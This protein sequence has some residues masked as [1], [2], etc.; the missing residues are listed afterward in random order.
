MAAIPW[1]LPLLFLTRRTSP[2]PGP[3]ENSSKQD[4]VYGWAEK[5]GSVAKQ[6][7]EGKSESKPD[8]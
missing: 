1:F 7:Q 4:I 6:M 8:E 5:D 3:G 2:S